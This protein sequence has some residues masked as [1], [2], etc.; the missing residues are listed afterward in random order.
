MKYDATGGD[1]YYMELDNTISLV[2][3]VDRLAARMYPNPI[4][5]RPAIVI[6]P[7]E[8]AN[9]QVRL[10]ITSVNGQHVL[11]NDHVHARDIVIDPAFM[12]PGLYQYRITSS[13][14]K[15]FSGRFVV[16]P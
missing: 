16:E 11:V 2:P 10:E 15:E 3:S 13:D 1:L 7:A 14:G 5:K 12:A 8:Q 6:L 4:S 9:Q